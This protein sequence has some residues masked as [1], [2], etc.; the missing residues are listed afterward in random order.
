MDRGKLWQLGYHTIS[1]HK[2]WIDPI[3]KIVVNQDILLE[4]AE[5]VELGEEEGGG[6]IR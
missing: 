5:Q 2:H 6:A 3:A 4:T 1:P